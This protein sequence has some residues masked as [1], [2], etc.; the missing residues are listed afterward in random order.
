[1][2]EKENIVFDF[3]IASQNELLDGVIV[4]SHRASKAM[5]WDGKWKLNRRV[6]E[7]RI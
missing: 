7:K 4:A 5:F 6:N 3:V 2:K 1:M